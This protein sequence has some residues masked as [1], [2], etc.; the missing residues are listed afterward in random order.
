ML[1]YTHLQTSPTG[2]PS[3]ERR[4]PSESSAPTLYQYEI[5]YR[6]VYHIKVVYD[7]ILC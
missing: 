3:A 7:R 6:S 1:L 2:R 5:W 4:A